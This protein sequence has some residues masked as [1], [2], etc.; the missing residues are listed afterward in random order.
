MT[1]RFFSKNNLPFTYQTR[2]KGNE[3]ALLAY[4]KLFGVLQRRSVRRRMLWEPYGVPEV[5]L[6]PQV[7]HTREDV[8]CHQGDP[9]R[10]DVGERRESQKLHRQTLEGLIAR[11]DKQLV[12]LVWKSDAP[13]SFTRSEGASP[14]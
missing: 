2:I 14:T 9:G 6:H 12:A 13:G 5:G 1:S 10:K 11:A 8:Q 3:D 4:A 7:W